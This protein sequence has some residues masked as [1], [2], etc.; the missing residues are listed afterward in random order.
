MRRLTTTLALATA[1]ALLSSVGQPAATT[2][3]SPGTA[4]RAGDTLLYVGP[5]SGIGFLAK[6][7]HNGDSYVCQRTK[8]N[9]ALMFYDNHFA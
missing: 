5:G 9:G 4:C 1:A 8:P 7:D 2:E 3:A 6:H